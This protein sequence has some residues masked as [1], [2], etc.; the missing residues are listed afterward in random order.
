MGCSPELTNMASQILG[1]SELMQLI[2]QVH[3]KF[4][5]DEVQ[6]EW[7]QDSRHR[8]YGTHEW[9]DV[10]GLGSFVETITAIDA[11]TLD[12]GPIR[13]IPGSHL[14]GHLPVGSDGKTLP[15][16][17]IDCDSA[18]PALLNPGD[19]LLLGPYT[20]HGSA[21]NHSRTSRRIFLNG[22]AM[23]GANKREYPW[24]GKGRLIRI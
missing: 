8:R 11:M 12:N 1:S 23:P 5:G 17:S 10:N 9:T 24:L 21:P 18:I 15:S 14:S 4:P 6:F 13:V 2:N 7:H 20:I 16:S 22:F 19:V 3:Y